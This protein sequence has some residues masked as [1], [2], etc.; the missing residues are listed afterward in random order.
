MILK[1]LEASTASRH[2]IGAEYVAVDFRRVVVG[3]SSA[4]HVRIDAK[5]V[6]RAHVALEVQRD[7]V[8]VENLSE[9]S[10]TTVNSVRV[11]VGEAIIVPRDTF[12]VQAG[13]VLLEVDPNEDTDAYHGRIERDPILL[14]HG[15]S[16]SPTFDL[17]GQRLQLAAGPSRLLLRLAQ[18]PGELVPHE[19]LRASMIL[20]DDVVG[21]GNTVQG[22]TYIRNAIVAHL[23]H[24]EHGCAVSDEIKSRVSHLAARAGAREMSRSLIKSIRGHGLCLSLDEPMV[25]VRV[26][27]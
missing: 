25:S 3:R 4:S 15:S 14:V 20:E 7:H 10:I 16:I 18:S 23:V 21:G 17:C 22:A 2:L 24:P 19:S 26:M 9:H 27:E 13:G 5:T 12:A 8:L 1:I 11:E 6:S